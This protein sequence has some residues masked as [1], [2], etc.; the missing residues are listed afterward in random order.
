M[1]VSMP[2][3]EK[4]KLLLKAFHE[5]AVVVIDEINS[6][7]LMERLLNTLLMGKTPRGRDSQKTGFYDNRN[8][9]PC[10]HGRTPGSK[11]GLET[12]NTYSHPGRIRHC[13]NDKR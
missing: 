13:G 5:G 3:D 12:T 4:E 1:P 6:S 11:S 2:L 8:S 10:L 9:K 7:A